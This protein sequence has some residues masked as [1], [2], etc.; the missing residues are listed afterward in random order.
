MDTLSTGERGSVALPPQEVL[1]DIARSKYFKGDEKSFDDVFDRVARGLAKD[2]E[3][4]TRFLELFRNGFIGGGRIMSAGGTSIQ[5]TLINC[6]VQEVN[7]CLLSDEPSK[8]GIY[9]ALRSAARTMQMGGGVGYDFSK[10]RPK[11]ALVKKTSSFAS[12]PLS[13]MYVFDQSCA[14]VE[15][16]G[17]RRG[18]QMGV[19]RV[20]HPDV[21]EFIHAKDGL[22]VDEL[23]IS[24]EEQAM[25][26][27]LLATN[28][29]FAEKMRQGFTKLRNFNL[30]VAVTDMFMQA[31]HE[32][33]EFE[34]V[35]EA[36]PGPQF[37]DAWKR[38]DGKWVYRVVRA[39]DLWK[40]IMESTYHHAEPGVLFIDRMN[41][42]NN[43]SYCEVIEASNPCAEQPLPSN[44]CCDLGSINLTRFVINP[45]EEPTFDFEGLAAT[46]GD[47]V[48]LLDRV[49]DVTRWPHE[50]QA[51]EARNKR[52]VGLGFLGLGDALTMMKIPY[53][54][55]EGREFAQKVAECMFHA[56]YNK[57]VDLA[58][59]LGAFPLFNADGFLADGHT[60]SRLPDAI[61]NRIRKHGIRN[62]HLLSIAPTG[63]ISLTFGGNASNG[64]EPA[65]GW[66]HDRR[67]RN[68]D[69][70]ERI[71]RVANHALRVYESLYG[72]VQ[73]RNSQEFDTALP[74]YFR[75]AEQISAL[76][77]MK[78]CA[79]VAPYICTAIS[80]T[81]NV[82]ADYPFEDFE[83]IYEEAYKAGLK[84]IS[85]FRPNFVLGSVLISDST[86][87]TAHAASQVP[88]IDP[89]T[90]RIDKR[91]E[92][93]LEGITEQV[94]YVSEGVRKKAYVTI[95]FTMVKGVVDGKEVTIERP[96]EFFFPAS[97]KTDGQQWIA[98]CMR[99]LS[100][101][102]RQGGSIAKML[103]NM[104]EVVWDKGP[105][106]HGFYEKPDGTKVPRFHESEVAAFA[107]AF[108]QILAYR[109]YLDADGNRVPV[110][111]LAKRLSS[112]QYSEQP[113]QALQVSEKPEITYKGRR[114]S[115]CGSY[116]VVKRDGCD[117]CTHCLTP[118]NC[119]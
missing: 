108:Q 96:V 13:Y 52:R 10:L 115:A 50:A 109:G 104:R 23:P 51:Q 82:A 65:F 39:R 12:G 78:M 101:L 42:D 81:V 70:S 94:V 59:E 116:S 95:N 30:S 44:G 112:K 8:P 45:F 105:V 15:S 111:A 99:I 3:Q 43:L 110:A 103:H 117:I 98:A 48:E 36:E 79:A 67:V 64:I 107:F 46:T 97:Q 33:A 56:A 22:K 86:K 54:G 4:R 113:E 55:E 89:L 6:F 38:A 114:C 34:L 75:R 85:T 71:I 24:G 102:A 28:H 1:M 17:A 47:A 31:V 91:P 25:F 93:R 20:D 19:L 72:E 88:D 63:T 37:P 119:G 9:D 32:D 69:N 14:T 62:S 80:K 68:P 90:S 57:S 87:E 74:G 83:A 100:E 41:T 76:D 92:G 58:V 66:A 73:A 5:A 7:D 118:G 49:L 106:Q 2:D 84:G 26:N 40:H 11:G 16:A 35:H 18:A 27:R 53:D 77:H 21:F 60:A 29:E 61:K